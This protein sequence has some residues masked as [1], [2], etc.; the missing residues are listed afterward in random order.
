MSLY[1]LNFGSVIIIKAKVKIK[2]QITIFDRD[3]WNGTKRVFWR[4]ENSSFR[5]VKNLDKPVEKTI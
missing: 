5:V 3:K 4:K 1:P 2:I